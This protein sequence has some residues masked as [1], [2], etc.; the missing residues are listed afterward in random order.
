MGGAA[1][2]R[3][4]GPERGVLRPHRPSSS[5]AGASPR[6]ERRQPIGRW[7]RP[8]AVRALGPGASGWR[9]SA[10]RWI[11]RPVAAAGSERAG[12]S[13]ASPCRPRW[14]VPVVGPVRSAASVSTGAS[15]IHAISD[16]RS[17]SVSPSTTGSW[18]A[19]PAGT[20][21]SQ[22]R[23]SRCQRR[24]SVAVATTASDGH[25]RAGIHARRR[26][27]E[28]TGDHARRP[29]PSRRGRR[30]RRTRAA[31]AAGAVPRRRTPMP[32]R[33]ACRTR[34]TWRRALPARRRSPTRRRLP[35]RRPDEG[36]DAGDRSQRD[37]HA[38]RRQRR[39][40]RDRHGDDAGHPHDGGANRGDGLD[41]VAAARSLPRTPPASR[42]RR[43]RST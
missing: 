42:P 43:R 29:R 19:R 11:A 23:D 39:R 32:A 1:A 40:R 22:R 6:S 8:A 9:G 7:R 10:V 14:R 13:R 33:T 18:S 41:R 25:D 37:D 3:R 36:G 28:R 15:R 24:G 20:S 2:P 27:Q 31:G 5:T 38:R 4:T 34:P 26:E 30:P 17:I 16:R 21:T 35:C 12:P